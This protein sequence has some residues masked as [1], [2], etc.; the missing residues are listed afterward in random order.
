[1]GKISL[2]LIVGRDDIEESY[3][4]MNRQSADLESLVIKL[5]LLPPLGLDKSHTSY[6]ALIK[7]A[8]AACD[9]LFVAEQT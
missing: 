1:M 7:V 8:A 6:W 9:E 5:G 2:G 4:E 3:V